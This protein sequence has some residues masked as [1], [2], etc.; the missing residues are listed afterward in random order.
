MAA[1]DD[2]EADDDE[3][4]A[5]AVTGASHRMPRMCVST[6]ICRSRLLN[7]LGMKSVMP[8]ARH[9]SR[10]PG[11]TLA[12]SAAIGHGVRPVVRSSS[13]MRRVASKP[14]RTTARIQSELHGRWSGAPSISGMLQSISTRSNG[15]CDLNAASASTPVAASVTCFPQVHE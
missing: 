2:D 5:A 8:A 3:A 12:V 10:E 14:A 7:G 1:A 11:T 9:S 15:G 13:R 4:A 6:I